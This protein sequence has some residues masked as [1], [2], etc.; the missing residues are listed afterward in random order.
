M[1]IPTKF[2]LFISFLLLA[3]NL[4]HAQNRNLEAHEFPRGDM[5]IMFYN[6]ENLFD[7]EDDS[8][9][10]DDDF[11]PQGMKY[12]SYKKYRK[13]LYNISKVITAI[14]QWEMPEIVGLCEIE[15]RF[16]L[17]ELL[18]KT[19]LNKFDYRIVHKESPDRR[20]IDV[21]L[22]YRSSQFS[23]IEYEAVRV[24]F[25][26]A[27]NRPTR[28]ILYVKG[29]TNNND[30]LHLFVNHWPSRWGGQM[31]TDR[32]RR[33]A[34]SVLKRKTDSL[35]EADNNPK[36]IIMGD[37]NDYPENGSLMED[38]DAKTEFEKPEN[39]QL[40]N[41][42]FYLQNSKGKG[43]H[44]HKGEWGV[45]DQLIVSGAL[46]KAESKMASGIDNAHVFDAPFLLETDE[47]HTGYKAFR[48]YIGMKFHD[49]FSDHLPVYID[50]F[51][52]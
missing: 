19:A 38:L 30:T 7:T 39:E 49:G 48:T 35:F 33:Y 37:L 8:L 4:L 41:L 21:A 46:L 22:L 23:L 10:R 24:R 28:D 32:K 17:T 12:W 51:E 20:G 3:S 16:V 27:A 11:T 47:N 34:A 50:L 36:I 31:A 25:P 14:G 15:N 40:Y 13:K 43:T 44:K 52:K 42:A 26:F 6:A 29:R 2:L 5:R 18:Q 9:K 45:L 1:K